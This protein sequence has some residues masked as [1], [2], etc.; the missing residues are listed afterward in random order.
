MAQQKR[1]GG[2]LRRPLSAPQVSKPPC[3]EISAHAEYDVCLTTNQHQVLF[4]GLPQFT[5]IGAGSY[6]SA[7]AA[8][9]PDRIVKLTTD[10][11]DVAALLQA[12]GSPYVVDVDRVYTL[13]QG[14]TPNRFK[15]PRAALY[16]IVAERV[17]PLPRAADR[18][19]GPLAAARQVIGPAKRG[20]RAYCVLGQTVPTAEEI[21]LCNEVVD[22]IQDFDRRGIRWR[23]IHAGNLGR[24]LHGQLKVLDAGATR[25]ELREMPELLEGARRCPRRR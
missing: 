20:N 18:R 8:P 17:Q 14:A 25:S 21:K 13:A 4:G 12:Q 23:D 16:A 5:L 19:Q 10:A 22:A 7:F 6:A 3:L 1:R 2:R 15:G 24:D 11:S 9:Q